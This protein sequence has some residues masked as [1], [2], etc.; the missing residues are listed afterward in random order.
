MMRFGWFPPSIQAGTTSPTS[1]RLDGAGEW[2][3]SKVAVPHDTSSVPVAPRG[4][5]KSQRSH[6]SSPSPATVNIRVAASPPRHSLS[7]LV[8]YLSWPFLPLQLHWWNSKIFLFEWMFMKWFLSRRWVEDK[9]WTGGSGGRWQFSPEHEKLSSPRPLRWV[10]SNH[11]YSSFLY[12]A[13]VCHRWFSGRVMAAAALVVEQSL[14]HRLN[15]RFSHLCCFY[16][17]RLFSG[18]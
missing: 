9:K 2:P 11:L 10:L 15:H 14:W 18:C 8:P 5:D 6:L 16:H 13:H 17:T 7:Q 3:H 4:I 1:C 12:L